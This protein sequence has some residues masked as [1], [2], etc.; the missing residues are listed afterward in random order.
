ML[1]PTMDCPEARTKYVAGG[2]LTTILE[3]PARIRR[4]SANFKKSFITA[5]GIWE[6]A[7]IDPNGAR[8]GL[9]ADPSLT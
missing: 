1:A 8:N 4:I 9:T 6:E 2:F 5:A 7:S 3:T